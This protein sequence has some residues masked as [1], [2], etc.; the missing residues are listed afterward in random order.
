[1]KRGEVYRTQEKF[2]E[3]GHKPSFYVIVS[4][5]FIAGNDDVDTVICAPIYGESLGLRSEVL[6]GVEEGLPKGSA[7]RCDFLTLLFKRKLTLFVSTLAAGKQ[8][9]LSLAL[10]YALQIKEG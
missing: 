5:D 3:R 4:R 8:R 6:V 9:E 7:I 1:M 10:A 2:P